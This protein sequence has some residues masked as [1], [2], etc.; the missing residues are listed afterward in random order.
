MSGLA[1]RH[2]AGIVQGE[3]R[4]R[5]LRAPTVLDAGCGDGAFLALLAR[6]LPGVFSGFDSPDYGLQTQEKLGSLADDADIRIT[7]PDGSW[8][9]PDAT[10]D[11]VVSNQVGEHVADLTTFCAE[12][13]RVLRPGGIGIHAFPLRHMVIEPHMHLALVHRVRDHYLRAWLIGFW[14]RCGRGIYA[15]QAIPAGVDL[16]RFSR[17][18]ADYSRTYTTYRTWAQVCDEFHRH[19]FRVSYRHTSRLAQRG[20]TQLLGRECGGRMLPPPLEA[21]MFPLI[22]TLLSV[23]LV[24]EKA[25]DYDF[26]WRSRA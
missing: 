12:H 17:I 13:A 26:G 2:L 1:H 19:G 20:L 10:F 23:T 15:S 5:D 4:A 14:S 11:M 9:F 3:A 24:V 25:Q 21:V 8:P 16:G 18:H 22:R 7:N 6:T